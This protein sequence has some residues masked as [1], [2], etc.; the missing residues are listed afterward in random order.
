LREQIR[1]AYNIAVQ[2]EPTAIEL[3][4]ALDVVQT[5]GP[6]PL[7]RALFNCNEVIFVP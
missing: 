3:S 7:C 5:H 4:S 6:E 2:R 1:I